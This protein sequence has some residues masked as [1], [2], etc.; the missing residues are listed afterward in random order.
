MWYKWILA[1]RLKSRARRDAGMARRRLII[2]RESPV[3]YHI[4]S[5]DY[6]GFYNTSDSFLHAVRRGCDHAKTDEEYDDYDGNY[7]Y[8]VADL[9]ERG[10]KRI[11]Y[12]TVTPRHYPVHKTLRGYWKPVPD[13]WPCGNKK[14]Y[15]RIFG[16]D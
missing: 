12:K 1:V 9:R 15:E 6:K 4:I 2:G 11:W 5:P 13:C 7:Q 3:K 16:P 14:D 8:T 10:C